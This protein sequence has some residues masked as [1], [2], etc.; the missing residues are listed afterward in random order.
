MELSELFNFECIKMKKEYDEKT[1]L[2]QYNK[3][4]EDGKNKKYTPIIIL[5]DHQELMINDIKITKEDYG[6]LDIFTKQ[7]IDNYKNVDVNSFFN[8]RQLQY[9]E[10]EHLIVT[11]ADNIY[12]PSNSLYLENK[13]NNIYIAKIP[14]DKVYEVMAYIPMGGFNDCPENSVHI[15]IA[16]Y[17]YEK[18]NAYPICIGS[19]SIQYKVDQKIKKEKLEQLALEQ[20]YY[21]GN[22]IW[23]GLESLNNLKTA[24]ENSKVWYFWWD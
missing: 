10:E 3:L 1:I 24:L 23:Q 13:N 7:C 6:S 15:A 20:Y 9:E 11:E 22:I 2:E 8:K 5:E 19:D 21:C 12:E 18:Y 14:T 16:K 4:K 17:W